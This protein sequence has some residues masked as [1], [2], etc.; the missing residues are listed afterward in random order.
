MRHHRKIRIEGTDLPG[1]VNKCIRNGI[2]LKDLRY[3]NQLESTV[4]VK[5]DDYHRLKKIAGHSYRM[6]T[7][8]EG[9]TI[10]FLNKIKSNIPTIIGAFLLGALIFYQGLFVAEI[11]VDGYRSITEAEIRQ[12]LADAGLEEGVRKPENYDDIK[13]AL[14]EN[15]RKITWV[16][17][18]EDGRSIR[19]NIAEAGK[20]E[21]AKEKDMTPAHIVAS[22]SG[23]IEKIT[24][25]QGNAR[26]QKGDYVNK[27][28]ILISGRYKYQSTDYSKGDGFFYMYSHAEG[29]V[30]AKVPRQVTFYM[31]KAQPSE[32]L[33][34]RSIP[35][36][37][38]SIGDMQIDTAKMMNRYEISVR[39]EAVLM[40]LVQ[41]LPLKISF[42]K[43]K[44]TEAEK[45]RISPEKRKAVTEAAIRQYK[46]E[47]MTSGEEIVSYDIA[48][49]ETEN[50][51][52]ADVF[53]EVL[54]DIGEERKIDMKNEEK[55]EK[56]R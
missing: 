19:V 52:I 45:Q 29:K 38:I 6:T 5:D 35:G 51:I 10:P 14:Y 53:M 32:K 25:L 56:D 3:K 20:A 54:E 44:E 47:E 31:Q 9:G 11:R 36:L 27:G 18:Y 13:A 8:S 37:Y 22:R 50:L 12:T 48:F 26:V 15:H 7:I 24:P 39:S 42:V 2:L 34:G 17:I 16:S 55:S 23:I 49:S 40:D 43:V 4:E 33:T 28:D 41:P 46:R 30:L 21:E 1:I